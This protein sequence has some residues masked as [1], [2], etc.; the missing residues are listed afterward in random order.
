MFEGPCRYRR[1]FLQMQ[2][3]G[4]NY[5]QF[6]NHSINLLNGVK[7]LGSRL[8]IKFSRAGKHRASIY[9]K[10]DVKEYIKVVGFSNPKHKNKIGT[11]V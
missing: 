5:I 1:V 2:E 4:K 9:K 6:T 8:G 7:E 11:M 10:E 3:R